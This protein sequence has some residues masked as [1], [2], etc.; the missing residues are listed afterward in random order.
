MGP[1][2][3]ASVALL[4]AV[5][6]V[7]EWNFDSFL[8]CLL[9]VVFFYYY[10]V[11]L[12]P[13][14]PSFFPL[15]C[16]LSVPT[17]MPLFDIHPSVVKPSQTHLSTQGEAL[18]VKVIFGI[19]GRW[20]DVSGRRSVVNKRAGRWS[21]LQAISVQSINFQ[22]L[23]TPKIEKEKNPLSSLSLLSPTGRPYRSATGENI[24]VLKSSCVY[25]PIHRVHCIVRE[26][27]PI[28]P[29]VSILCSEKQTYKSVLHFGF[30][31][32]F[33]ETIDTTLTTKES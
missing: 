13:P 11:S 6:F 30:P 9:L 10:F 12:L 24:I 33:A 29:L 22:D 21:L 2:S 14:P 5:T 7:P 16:V 20:G 23:P 26:Q 27:L 1:S 17:Q 3:G 25:R 18:K 8:V 15:E 32:K 4:W 28:N 31:V 19:D